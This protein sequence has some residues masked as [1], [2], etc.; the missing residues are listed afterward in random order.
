MDRLSQIPAIENELFTATDVFFKTFRV[1]KILKQ[2]NAYK[3]KGIQVVFIFQYLF[4]LIF[5]GRSL[6]MDLKCGSD[7]GPRKDAFY[8]FLNST[9]I[10]WLRF[11]TL[12]A[13][14]VICNFMEK[15]TAERRVNV[16]IA[17]DTMYEKEYG[18]KAEL[19]SRIY[20]H[21]KKKHSLG[22]R[23]LTLCWS[24]GCSTVP[25]NGVL[26]ASSK[27]KNIV[28]RT[29]D[30]V[31]HR[32][33]GDK[34]RKLAR[35]KEP[36]ALIDLIEEAGQAGIRA[37][38]L[39]CDS[40]FPSAGLF[41]AVKKRSM[42]VISMAKKT[43][44]RYYLYNGRQMTAMQ[45]YAA[46]KK[47]RGCSKYLLSA[48][49]AVEW[50]GDDKQEACQIPVRLVFVRNRNKKKEYL[51]LISTDTTIS[52]EEIIRLYGRRWGIEV[53]FKT[54]K[55]YLKL[56]KECHALSYDA[57]TAYAAIVFARYTLLSWAMRT[58]QDGRSMGEL[59]YSFCDELPD[60]TWIEAFRMLMEC[61]RQ[62]VSDE[63]IM[64]DANV[65]KLMETFIT[66]L[67]QAIQNKLK[68]CA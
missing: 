35:K 61:F 36:E 46:N 12:L 32:T 59:F 52:P 49:A 26:L 15:L 66:S 3:A 48:D 37:S 17:D 62:V 21:A 38:Y 58:E 7:I 20:D 19:L 56:T 50:R 53:F 13:A 42:N 54:C 25:V 51:V 8:R 45:I 28:G 43:P 9:S 67:P 44:K 68:K 4:K 5:A 30:A 55:S 63:I 16:L 18:R 65:E 39:L 29:A 47:R 23:L 33:C 27:D 34:R 14:S 31:D 41:L 2:S 24:D 40:W 11:T 1:G 10:N 6:Y 64:S 57:L 22:Y 60:I